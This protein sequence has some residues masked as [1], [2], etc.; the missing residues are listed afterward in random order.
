MHHIACKQ[1]RQQK[2]INAIFKPLGKCP[3]SSFHTHTKLRP[4]PGVWKNSVGRLGRCHCLKSEEK[5]SNKSISTCKFLEHLRVGNHRRAYDL[6]TS[7]VPTAWENRKMSP[8]IPGR[9]AVF[10]GS[11]Y[12]IPSRHGRAAVVNSFKRT[13]CK[14]IAVLHNASAVLLPATESC[15]VE[16]NQTRHILSSNGV[17]NFSTVSQPFK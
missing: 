2:N 12:W 1:F 15:L 5:E 16:E 6:A 11:I 13:R 7:K 10:A 3:R 9:A 4:H 17:R 14:Q 8:A